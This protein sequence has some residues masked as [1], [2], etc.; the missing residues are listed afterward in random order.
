METMTPQPAG[1]A[2]QQENGKVRKT[3]FLSLLA[4]VAIPLIMLLINEYVVEI[5]EL[6]K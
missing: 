2:G 3:S 6:F 5:T 1:T 4:V